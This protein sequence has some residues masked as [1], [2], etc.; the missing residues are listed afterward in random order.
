M[1]VCVSSKSTSKQVTRLIKDFKAIDI[2]G[3]EVS[4]A[5]YMGYVLVIVN[6]AR[7]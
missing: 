6:T 3:N 1:G 7:K 5:D 4:L 2:L